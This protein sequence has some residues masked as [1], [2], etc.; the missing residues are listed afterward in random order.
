M[1]K[2]IFWEDLYYCLNVV[3]LY[4]LLLCERCEDIIELIYFFLNDFLINYNWLICDLFLSIM[5]E[6]FYYN[7]LGNICEFWNVVEWFVVF[8]IDG[9]IK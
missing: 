9:I 8:V 6:L 2:G 4:I 3:S 1:R 5:Y 7:W